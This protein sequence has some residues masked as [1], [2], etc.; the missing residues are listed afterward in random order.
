VVMGEFGRTPKINKDAGRDHWGWCQSVLLAGGGI[1]GGQVV[2][3]SDRLGAYPT[4]N[5]VDPVNIHATLYHC[6]GLDP[7]GTMFD[8][9]RRPLPL[10]TGRV[11]ASLVG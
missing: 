5:P 3:S 1:R 6:M 10:S 11:V 4:A 8:H 2:G 7:E 9:L